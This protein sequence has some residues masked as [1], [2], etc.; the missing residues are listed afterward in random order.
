MYSLFQ[1]VVLLL[2]V[3]LKRGKVKVGEEVD[4]IG[5]GETLKQL[6]LALKCSVRF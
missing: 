3:E 4:I 6:L 2:L 1:V 5:F